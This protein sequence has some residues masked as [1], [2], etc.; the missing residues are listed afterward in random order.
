M[1]LI[2]EPKTILETGVAAGF[3][4]QSFLSAL[5]KNGSGKLYSSDYPYFR[6]PNPEKYIGIVVD[7]EL[8]NNWELY[9]EGD[10]ANLDKI[11]RKLLRM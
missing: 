10:K 1:V 7:K 8:Q 6:I 11:I 4:S 9:I 2:A 3:S 5:A